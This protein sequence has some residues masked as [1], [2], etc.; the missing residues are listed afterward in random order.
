MTI[1][2]SSTNLRRLA[3]ILIS[4]YGGLTAASVA[5]SLPIGIT[6]I[7]TAV[8]PAMV[9]IEHWADVTTPTPP[10]P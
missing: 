10:T 8:Y 2:I 4:V 9:V 5:P 7:L 1:P 6:A 3:G